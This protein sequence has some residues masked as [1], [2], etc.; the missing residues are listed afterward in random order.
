MKSVCVICNREYLEKEPIENQSM[1][2][3]LCLSCLKMCLIPI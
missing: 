2:H 1:T 3:G